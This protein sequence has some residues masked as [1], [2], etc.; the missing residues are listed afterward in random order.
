MPLSTQ[1]PVAKPKPNPKRARYYSKALT[2]EDKHALAVGEINHNLR[3]WDG[4]DLV[5]FHE[6]R[7][8]LV[9]RGMED[10]D[11]VLERIESEKETSE[12]NLLKQQKVR[13]RFTRLPTFEVTKPTDTYNAQA[14]QSM[15]DLLALD[16]P[17]SP[18]ISPTLSTITARAAPARS[19][20][21]TRQSMHIRQRSTGDY[22]SRRHVSQPSSHSSRSS[23]HIS[24]S[25]ATEARTYDYQP[26]ITFDSFLSP[27][28]SGK[29]E[30]FRGAD[31]AKKNDV[32]AS[33][34]NGTEEPLDSSK[35]GG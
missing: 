29:G 15:S 11:E 35:V 7:A 17:A 33:S 23:V 9:P 5:M 26:D 3:E 24:S 2:E 22:F 6:S 14:S 27:H 34:G 12:Q 13:H 31:N 28:A 16:V 25:L 8:A 4:R 19:V 18:R 32:Q 30:A 1:Q 10:R 20:A 21:S